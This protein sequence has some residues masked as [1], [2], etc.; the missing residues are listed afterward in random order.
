MQTMQVCRSR[1][2]FSSSSV[3][4][5][6]LITAIFFATVLCSAMQGQEAAQPAAVR[7]PL[8]TQ[9]LDESRLT[10][11]KGNTHPLA[12]PVFDLG[13]APAS[14]PME[15]M[16]LVLKR[17]PEQEGTLRKLLDDQQDKGSPNYH[18]WLTPEQFG[19]QFGPSDSDMQAI[20]SWLQSHGFQVG[21]TKGRTA[22]EFSGSAS[23]VKEAFH[24]TIH[25]Y[26]VNGEQHWANASDPKI[27]TALTPAVAGVYTLHNFVKKP[28]YR[29]SKERFVGTI[30]PGKPPQFTSSTGLH[31]LAPADFAT[32]Y[33]VA[34][35]YTATPTAITG[36]GMSIGVVGRS[37]II[38]SD[39]T[40]FRSVLGIGGPT[41]IVIVNGPDPGDISGDDLEATLDVSWSGAIAPGAQVYF[42][43]SGT[44][45]DTDGV[46]LSELY[47][48]E[49]NL[50]NVM[51]YSFGGCEPQFSAAEPLDLSMAEQ[52]AA[53]GI[54]FMAST[55]DAGAEGCDDPNTETVATQPI[56]VTLPASTPFTTAVG[57]TI[58]NETANGGTAATYWSATNN[59]TNGSSALSYIPEDVWNESCT[60]SCPASLGPNILAGG[61]G[62]SVDFPKPTWQAGVTG[63]PADKARDVPDIVFSAASNND[64][65]LLCFQ[66]SCA[67]NPPGF[68]G[69]GGTSASTPSF[70]GVM[71]LVDQKMSLGAEGAISGARQGLANYVLY[72]LAAAQQTAGT[73]CNASALPIPALNNTCVFYDVTV[74]N[75]AVPGETGYGTAT[76]SYQAGAGYDL[77][78]GLGSINVEN[79]VNQWALA[80]FRPTTTTLTLNGVAGGNT[81]P[82]SV[83]HGAAVTVAGT[84]APSSGTGAP[85]GDVSLVAAIGGVGSISNQTGILPQFTLASGAISGSTAVLPGGTYAVTAHYAGDGTFAPSDS[86]PGV[87]VTVTPESST[88]TVTLLANDSSGNS[89]TSPFPFGSLVFVRSDVVGA[90][91]KGV[92]TG[93]VKF[94]DTF[95]AIP[96]LNPQISPP[97]P[98][99]SSPSVN[100]QG[101]TSIGDG[102]I[103]FDAGNHTISA[104]YQGDASFNPSP[105]S[106]TVSFTVQPGFAGVSGPT[107][108]TI[109]A[110]G[111]TGTTTVGIIASTGFAAISFTCSGLP[112]EATC[113]AASATGKGPTTVVTTNITVTTTAPHTTML[114]SNERKYYYAV[115]FSGGLPLAGILLLASP[116]RRRWSALLGLIVVALL[117]T[118]P[119]CGGGGGST[120]TQD[121]GTPAGTYTVTLTAAATGA[122]SESGTFT[123]TVQ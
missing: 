50:S 64:P 58:F 79:L 29:L 17:S 54:S 21:A 123:L 98:V 41:P 19:K 5:F 111:G 28:M 105:V 34:P 89:L 97:V 95:G 72:P 102:I 22:L 116:K 85:M 51:T 92:P 30:V 46:T 40:D 86:S 1:S 90:S 94:T 55:G 52:A 20:T 104:T 74:G 91:G 67:T 75:N 80:I 39:I 83:A 42:V 121:P 115:V 8:I 107:A 81:T 2:S 15:R 7:S 61:G 60:T 16:L 27:P 3:F 99:S 69:V 47:I 84:V 106:N 93:S 32:I 96:T 37:D 25:K 13:T 73:K 56:A 26:A 11:L 63:I 6:S 59:S 18:K 87:Q 68:A 14:L 35:L 66:A 49:N 44:T 101:N 76:A 10:T 77:A 113:G 103:S 117:V 43:N 12:R 109:S 100:S 112:S 45:N 78:T 38:M 24:T 31:A 119:A 53:Q 118:V 48:L 114:R 71:A 57:G 88:T 110:P 23:Q 33:N 4:H 122:P 82:V 36:A 70:A 62:V 120:H 65:Y 108:V 9:P